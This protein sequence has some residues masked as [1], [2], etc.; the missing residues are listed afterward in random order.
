MYLTEVEYYHISQQVY[1]TP[2]S[3][4]APATSLNFKDPPL[5]TYDCLK[6]EDSSG[7]NVPNVNSNITD[8]DLNTLDVLR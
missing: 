4:P 7:L 3:S 5:L 8:P 1:V 2:G 6:Q